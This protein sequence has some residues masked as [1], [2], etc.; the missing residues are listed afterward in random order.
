MGTCERILRAPI[1]LSYTRHTSRFMVRVCWCIAVEEFQLKRRSVAAVPHPATPPA[2]WC[3]GSYCPTTVHSLRS[4]RRPRHCLGSSSKHTPFDF[5]LPPALQIVAAASSA[6]QQASLLPPNYPLACRSSGSRCCPLRC[7]TAW[8]GPPC[9]CPSSF[10]SCY[11]VSAASLAKIVH[12][13]SSVANVL[14]NGL[15]LRVPCAPAWCLAVASSFNR[16]HP[17]S[18]CCRDRGDWRLY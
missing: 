8:A 11:W 10:P 2:S 17:A 4:E 6:S 16:P 18:L 15:L 12:A 13:L 14:W 7:G 3:I 9:L 5:L 1:P